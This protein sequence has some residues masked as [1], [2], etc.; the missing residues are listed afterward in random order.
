MT[1]HKLYMHNPQQYHHTT[2][3]TAITGGDKPVVRLAE[4]IFHPQGGGQ[5]A[6][7]GTI[8]DMIV[9][10]VVH[11]DGGEGRTAGSLGA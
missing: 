10:H 4:T 5:K 8:G 7:R 1:T 2:T 11:A 3:I 9:T 6:D